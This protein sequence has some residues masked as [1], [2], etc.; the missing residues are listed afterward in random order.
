MLPALARLWLEAAS[1]S[2]LESHDPAVQALQAGKPASVRLTEGFRFVVG[3]VRQT[4][5]P[6]ISDKD[7]HACN[8]A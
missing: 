3:A 8:Q 7:F 4:T 6:L 2:T 5:L 1:A